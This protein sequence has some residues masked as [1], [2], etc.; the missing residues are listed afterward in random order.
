MAME[1]TRSKAR[2]GTPATHTLLHCAALSKR[3]QR[4][5]AALLG[6]NGEWGRRGGMGEPRGRRP[7][8][9]RRSGSATDG[10]HPCSSSTDGPDASLLTRGELSFHARQNRASRVG[11]CTGRRGGQVAARASG[12]ACFRRSPPSDPVSGAVTLPDETND[13]CE[14][15]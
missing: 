13:H 12:S 5:A 15:G 3:Q 6:W 8:I 10:W 9:N 4:R 2:N 1:R 7:R 14:L 11:V